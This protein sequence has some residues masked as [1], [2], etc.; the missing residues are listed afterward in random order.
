MTGGSSNGQFA[1]GTLNVTTSEGTTLSPEAT[2]FLFRFY[3]DSRGGADGGS[4]L[5]ATTRPISASLTIANVP[6][7]SRSVRVMVLDQYGLALASYLLPITVDDNGTTTTEIDESARESLP[8]LGVGILPSPLTLSVGSNRVATRHR[9][10]RILIRELSADN[11]AGLL[12]P[13]DSP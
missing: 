10:V 12:P 6:T 2:D 8:N 4:L 9:A 13:T 7:G 1:T 11:V 5:L 3:S